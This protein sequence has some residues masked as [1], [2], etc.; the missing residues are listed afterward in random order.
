MTTQ[1]KLE[2]PNCPALKR[3]LHELRKKNISLRDDY[4]K[5]R[6]NNQGLKQKLETLQV[7][8]SEVLESMTR[9]RL[10]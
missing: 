10:I 1:V 4:N 5:Y 6:K 9:P 2:C 7:Q 8:M 3:G